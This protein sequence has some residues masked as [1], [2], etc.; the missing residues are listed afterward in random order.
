MPSTFVGLLLFVVLLAP[1]LTYLLVAE[2]GPL[3]VR[4]LSVLRESATVALTS[5]VFNGIA[6]L[7]FAVTRALGPGLTPDVGRA[8]REGLP[9]LRTHYVAVT[10]WAVGVLGLACVLAGSWGIVLNA[11]DRLAT[12]RRR[13]WL[14]VLSPV[15]GVAHVSSWWK[16]L[17]DKEPDRRRRVTCHLDDGTR[18]EGWLLSLNAGVEETGDRDLALSAPLTVTASSGD[19]REV[20]FGA[21]SLSARHIVAMY[22][23]YL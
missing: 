2:R 23:D 12:L 5:I 20:R 11:T 14:R 15:G 4:G 19:V 3:P 21:V 1:G 9:Y 16:L 6:L 17:I 7:A 18:V 10:W 13:R 8:V 22:V